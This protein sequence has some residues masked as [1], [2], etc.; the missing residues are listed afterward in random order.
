M[1]KSRTPSWVVDSSVHFAVSKPILHRDA[2]CSAVI[3]GPFFLVFAEATDEENDESIEV[4]SPEG[5]RTQDTFRKCNSMMP[6][7]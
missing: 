1:A 4:Q 2:S 7:S 5:V 3:A 6:L